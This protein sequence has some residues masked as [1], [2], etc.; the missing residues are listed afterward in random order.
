MTNAFPEH[1]NPEVNSYLWV[2]TSFVHQTDVRNWVVG[3]RGL[4]KCVLGCV[5]ISE[6]HFSFIEGVMN[7]SV[8][9][10]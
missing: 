2:R 8:A 6:G 3:E 7:C 9:K 1:Y 4:G 10:W 5:T